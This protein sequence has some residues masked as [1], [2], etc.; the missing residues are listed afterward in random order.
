[1]LCSSS[2]LLHI[3]WCRV[4]PAGSC[5]QPCR[6]QW[7]EPSSRWRRCNHLYD[8]G[9]GD[10]G[11]WQRHNHG[12]VLPLETVPTTGQHFC[13]DPE[14]QQQPD[15]WQWV[16]FKESEVLKAQAELREMVRA[17]II[18]SDQFLDCLAGSHHTETLLL[19]SSQMTWRNE[20]NKHWL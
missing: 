7:W 9:T 5:W 18:S 4:P 14:H 13:S 6:K 16:H 10:S 20:L 2:C 19:H 11:P 12:R 1:M 8:P 15:V 17:H 3:R